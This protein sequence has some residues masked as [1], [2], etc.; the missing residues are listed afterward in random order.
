MEIKVVV[1]SSITSI[2]VT[3]ITLNAQ[4]RLAIRKDKKEELRK[5]VDNN[6]EI[7]VMLLKIKRNQE[8]NYYQLKEKIIKSNEL[9]LLLPKKLVNLFD[10]L[11][12]LLTLKGDDLKENLDKVRKLSSK[13]IKEIRKVGVDC[14]ELNK[15]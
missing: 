4:K 10:K 9:N 11:I 3:L 5:I 15:R 14:S 2:F 13:I 1:I 6:S 8:V 7:F 12:E